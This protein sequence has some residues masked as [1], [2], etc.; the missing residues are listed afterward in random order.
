[1]QQEAAVIAV[2]DGKGRVTVAVAV[3]RAWAMANESVVADATAAQ[4][5]VDLSSVGADSIFQHDRATPAGRSKLR[6]AGVV[7]ERPTSVSLT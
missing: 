7:A 6:A 5:G 4:D 3:Q 2:R 1:M